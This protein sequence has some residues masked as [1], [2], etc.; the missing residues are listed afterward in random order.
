MANTNFP[1]QIC[2]SRRIKG[3]D[4]NVSQLHLS[5]YVSHLN[6]SFLNVISQEVVSSLNLSHFFMKDWIFGYRYG[7]GVIAHEGNPLKDHSKISHGVHYPR[8]L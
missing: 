2:K 8:N 6:V 1:P 4:E 5:V 3:F 7:T